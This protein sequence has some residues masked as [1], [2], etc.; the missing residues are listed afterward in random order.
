[1]K[2]SEISKKNKGEERFFFNPKIKTF[3]CFAN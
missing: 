1:M 2:S 3:F